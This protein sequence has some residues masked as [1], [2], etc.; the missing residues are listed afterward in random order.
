MLAAAHITYF[1]S[2]F[3]GFTDE[4][5]A[6]YLTVDNQEKFVSGFRPDFIIYSAIP[7]F[8]GY[9]LIGKQ[10]IKSPYYNFLWCVYTLTNSVFLLCTYGSFIN[11]IAYLSWL[12]YPF[13]LLYPFVNAYWHERQHQYLRYAVYGH[14]GFTL[15]MV[16]IY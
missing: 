8:V 12:M 4:H 1:Q 2:L 16:L 11:R 5:G 10:K 9:Y 3:S 7:I 13:V 6:N 14:L 15:F